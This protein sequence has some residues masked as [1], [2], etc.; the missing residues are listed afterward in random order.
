MITGGISTRLIGADSASE[1]AEGVGGA[2]GSWLSILKDCEKRKAFA[3]REDRM[4]CFIA[5][6]I[7]E[8]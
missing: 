2:S 4:V 1:D 6:M 5:E 8:I 3:R 7:S